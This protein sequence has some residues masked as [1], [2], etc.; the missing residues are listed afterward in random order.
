MTGASVGAAVGYLPSHTHTHRQRRSGH[1]MTTADNCRVSRLMSCSPHILSHPRHPPKARPVW[2]SI[3]GAPSLGTWRRG[4]L[5]QMGFEPFR[6]VSPAAP[7]SLSPSCKSALSPPPPVCRRDDPTWSLPRCRPLH[8][9]SLATSR[10][11][12]LSFSLARH[13][14]FSLARH[15][16]RSFS[17]SLSPPR[18]FATSLAPSPAR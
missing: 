18:Y 10:A 4:A 13:L 8:H 11:R 14:A 1:A 9:P 6:F 16:T 5:A 3:R 12:S 7:L 2:R 15:L 17:L